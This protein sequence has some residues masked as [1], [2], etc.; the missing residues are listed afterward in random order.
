[1]SPQDAGEVV[2]IPLRSRFHR[3]VGSGNL[4]VLAGVL[5]CASRRA[6]PRSWFPSTSSILVTV[7]VSALVFHERFTRRYVVGL[8]L[9]CAGTAAMVVL[10]SGF[11]LPARLGPQVLGHAGHSP[12]LPY[13]APP[14]IRLGCPE[15]VRVGGRSTGTPYASR[16]RVFQR[17]APERSRCFRE[18]PPVNL[19]IARISFP[20]T[21]SRRQSSAL[22]P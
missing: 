1:M 10:R 7:G 11:A 20:V 14:R 5:S 12:L 4:R 16:S 18:L 22:A 21:A 6:S 9:L 3:R 15:T 8:G 19:S 17:V 2:A 13:R